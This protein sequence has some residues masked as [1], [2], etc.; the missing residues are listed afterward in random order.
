MVC[1]LTAFGAVAYAQTDAGSSSTV[2]IFF[3]ACDNQAVVNLN[4]T[5]EAG[6]D[7]YYQVFSSAQGTGTALTNIRQ[8]Q[9]D[10][11]Y[12]FS[13]SIAFT[14][15]TIPAG[16]TGSVVVYMGVEGNTNSVLSDRFL[17]DDIQDGCNSPQNALATSIDTGAGG[18][19]AVSSTTRAA[20]QIRSP[21][22]GFI[23][24]SVAIIPQDIVVIG[25]RQDIDSGRSQTP[26][27]I[28]AECDKYAAA[29][30]GVLYDNDNIVI[31]WSWFART[32]A[33]AQDH[34]AKAQYNVKLNTAPLVEV[35]VG[36]VEQRGVNY[37]VF[38]TANIGHLKPGQ[39]GVEYNVSWSEAHFDGYSDYGPD[40]DRP[41]E[42]STCTFTIEPNPDN[43]KITD[44][45]ALYSVR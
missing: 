11:T 35:G 13:E 24:P 29:A 36:A 43:L 27:I 2:T 3:V 16:S 15:G 8:V 32:Q 20:G 39:Y 4:G 10:G 30:P 9:V 18:T 21:F 34:I 25:A 6:L 19:G 41:S 14:G 33:Q 28:F 37:W 26:G 7:L 45:N 22:G 31:F 38:Y 40:T 23:N 42:S 44:Y 1:A 17:V 12:A 5:M